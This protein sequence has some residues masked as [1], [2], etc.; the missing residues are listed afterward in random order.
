MTRRFIGT[1]YTRYNTEDL[2]SYCEEIWQYA[3]GQEGSSFEYGEPGASWRQVNLEY[4]SGETP[5][6]EGRP[7]STGNHT[8]PWKEEVW[9]DPWITQ[10][11]DH[12]GG[13]LRIL[14][15]GNLDEY[16]PPQEMLAGTGEHVIPLSVLWQVLGQ[17]LIRV[18]LRRPGSRK[19][20]KSQA[21]V[22]AFVRGYTEGCDRKVHIMKGIQD[23]RPKKDSEQR[24]REL[25]ATYTDGTA[26]SS[27]RHKLWT[28]RVKLDDH[29]DFWLTTEAQRKRLEKR[30]GDPLAEALRHKTTAEV[31]REL[32][33]QYEQR[34]QAA[35][36]D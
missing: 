15:P 33:D 22:F 18:G 4:W 9:G 13:P 6:A 23:K 26:A 19:G 10:R 34:A 20:N 16:L 7:W 17:L 36:D 35:S 29:F 14:S 24:L 27:M 25:L 11:N 8:A 21:A 28:I 5:K 30:Q 1:N 3:K 2:E 31:L 32:A 12:N